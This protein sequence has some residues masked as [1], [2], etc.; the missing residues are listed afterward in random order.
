HARILD[1]GLARREADP[2][3]THEG[4]TVGTPRFMAPEQALDPGR[5]DGR[6]DLFALGAVLYRTISG[7]APFDGETVAAGLAR[8]LYDD[9]APLS[10][11]QPDLPEA[12]SLVIGKVLEKSP[13]HRFRD[14]PAFA[15]ALREAA[16]GQRPRETRTAPRWAWLA[17]TVVAAMVVGAL[18]F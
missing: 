7:I 4:G 13:E 17:A 12:I 18:A 1:L 14:A 15:A 2:R 8:L 9:P 11:L 5:I 16:R 3:L 6:A 10:M